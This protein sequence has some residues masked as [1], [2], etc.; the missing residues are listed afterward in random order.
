V[1]GSTKGPLLEESFLRRALLKKRS[2]DNLSSLQIVATPVAVAALA[3][4]VIALVAL[5]RVPHDP[6]LLHSTRLSSVAE[7]LIA[8]VW[9]RGSRGGNEEVMGTS[10][11]ACKN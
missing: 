1:V 3:T 6:S 2:C 9:C 5:A 7:Q 11:A 8:V 10:D 4:I